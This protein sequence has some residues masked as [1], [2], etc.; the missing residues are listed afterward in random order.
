MISLTI[1][2]R[3]V[4]VEPG[5]TILEAARENGISIPT[6]CYHE[7]L[8]PYSACRICLVEL[9]TPRGSSLVASCVY[10]CA[11][12]LVVYTNS[13]MV[14]HSRRMTIEL[15]MSGAAHIPLIRAMA[16]ELGVTEVRYTQEPDDCILCGLCVRV[17]REAIGAAAISFIGR[18]TKRQVGSPFKVQSDACI[19]CGA[20]AEICPT[21]AV[22][23]ED[24]GDKRILHTWNTTVALHACPECGRFFAPEPTAF[25]KEMLPEIA[26]LWA[27][28]PECRCKKALQQSPG[29]AAPLAT[30]P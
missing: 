7:A 11:E 9:E 17:C 13:D 27:L 18:G 30:A 15:L 22:R 26:A 6:L 19:G 3:E 20:C 21:G 24:R 25:L 8:E 10:P 2:S 12:G 4:K 29:V 14:L 1:D 5:A 28:C 23:M 16:E